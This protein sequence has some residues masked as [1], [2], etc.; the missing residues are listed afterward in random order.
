ME[1]AVD[2]CGLAQW[3]N[4]L[5]RAFLDTE[6]AIVDKKRSIGAG[7]FGKSIVSFRQKMGVCQTIFRLPKLL[8]HRKF[9]SGKK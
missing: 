9:A 3:I 8:G 5:R 4:H 7:F 2:V 6:G 1:L